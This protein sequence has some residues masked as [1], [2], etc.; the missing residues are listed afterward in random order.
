M[1]FG[2]LGKGN[3]GFGSSGWES[4]DPFDGASDSRDGGGKD[5]GPRRFWM[6]AGATKRVLFLDSEPFCLYEHSLYSINKSKDQVTCLKK[7]GI[8]DQCPLCD[9]ESWP[10]FV[11][12]FSVIDMGDV[13]NTKGGVTL[14]GWTSKKGV[15]YQFGKSLLG[16]KRGGKDKPGVLQKLKRLA[17]KYDND[18]SGT[19]W[20]VYRSGAK[21]E[22]VGDEFE[23][24]EK[25][26]KADW[27]NYLIGL[28][29]NEKYL[30]LT[31]HD[32]QTVFAPKSLDSLKRLVSDAGLGGA[33][34]G[35]AKGGFDD[36]DY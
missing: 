29:A 35:P 33:A 27:K 14:S 5:F 3:G 23:F 1:S 4:A 28:G 12:H 7:N 16:A 36:A 34:G 13:T 15:T 8:G 21:V 17:A 19:V 32:Y 18:L 25:V 20:D 30:D 6:P 10:S 24:V 31:P 22:S 9:A 11:G 2:S 26:K